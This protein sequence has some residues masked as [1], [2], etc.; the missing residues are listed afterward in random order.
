MKRTASILNRR[1]AARLHLRLVGGFALVAVSAGQSFFAYRTAI[2]NSAAGESVTRGEQILGV[3]AKVRSDLLQMEAGYSGFLLA[4]NDTFLDS[5]TAGALAYGTDLAAL[6]FPILSSLSM[7]PAKT[8]VSLAYTTPATGPSACQPGPP[9]SF[10][11]MFLGTWEVNR[12]GDGK[13]R[14]TKTAGGNTSPTPP[15]LAPFLTFATGSAS[16]SGPG[17]YFALTPA[18]TSISIREVVFG[19]VQFAPGVSFTGLLPDRID[20]GALHVEQ[21]D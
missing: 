17:S 15:A 1:T 11:Q 6:A 7:D 20:C 18:I 14:A 2:E 3:V 16:L 13:L 12:H 19:T 8:Y 5:Y 9:L 10:T 21:E 4:G